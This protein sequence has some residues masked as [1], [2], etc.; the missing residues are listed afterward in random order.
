MSRYSIELRNGSKLGLDI[1][2]GN[3][4]SSVPARTAQ[5]QE[6]VNRVLYQSAPKDRQVK[7]WEMVDT[8]EEWEAFGAGNQH[9]VSG[10]EPN[11]P[12]RFIARSRREPF[13]ETCKKHWSAKIHK[14]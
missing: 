13:C 8:D 5:L 14:V 9:I 6:I 3:L 2:S 1:R 12:H 10:P 7:D 4:S 11:V